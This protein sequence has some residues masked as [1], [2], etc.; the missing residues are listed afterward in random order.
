MRINFNFKKLN[1]EGEASGPV[2]MMPL[3]MVALHIGVAPG[4]IPGSALY[5]LPASV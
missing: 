3:V 4:F 1:L 5:W 2:V